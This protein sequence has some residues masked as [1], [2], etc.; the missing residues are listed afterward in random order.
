MTNH[1]TKV[2][3][4]LTEDER[5]IFRIIV[6]SAREF[7]SLE[8]EI[9][10][11]FAAA[12][13]LRSSSEDDSFSNF[14][15]QSL[16]GAASLNRLIIELEVV[17]QISPGQT[18]Q[19][20]EEFFSARDEILGED[21]SHRNPR[22]GSLKSEL[23]FSFGDSFLDCEL[24]DLLVGHTAFSLVS[25][26]DSLLGWGCFFGCPSAWFSEGWTWD[27]LVW[28][29]CLSSAS[30]A[31]TDW[32]AGEDSFHWTLFSH[33]VFLLSSENLASFYSGYFP[34]AGKLSIFGWIW[35]LILKKSKIL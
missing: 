7:S 23:F 31:N 10:F 22:T 35:I 29:V 6:S 17:F 33:L 18:V 3:F 8:V 16:F 20:L 34:R 9:N 15:S 30:G 19:V 28:G 24:V 4:L 12:N 2:I 14:Q 21:V 5:V 26:D 32:A 27:Q 11:S 13:T 25:G 1:V